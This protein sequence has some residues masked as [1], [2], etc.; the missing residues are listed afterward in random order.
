VDGV[1]YVPHRYADIDRHQYDWYVISSHKLFGPHL[2]ILCGRRSIGTTMEAYVRCDDHKTE[3][4]IQSWSPDSSSKNTD[5]QLGTVNF[6][7]CEGIRGLGRYFTDLCTFDSKNHIGTTNDVRWNKCMV[8]ETYRNIEQ[9]EVGLIH[10]L[11]NGLQRSTK[12]R[13]IGETTLSTAESKSNR[14]PIISFVHAMIPSSQIVEKCY[15][16]GVICRNGTFLSTERFQQRYN[17]PDPIDGVVRFSMAHFNTCR[18][19][20]YAI[21]IL[22][23]I[24]GWW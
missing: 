13:I 3:T 18:E 19:V 12:V 10:C 17:F 22:E 11:L 8:L 9:T 23:A 16:G 5:I 21:G 7:A 6:E 2:G 20:Q 14:L 15:Q 4:T 24:P 1:T